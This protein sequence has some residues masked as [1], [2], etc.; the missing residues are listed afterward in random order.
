MVSQTWKICR[1]QTDTS[2][3]G[4]IWRPPQSWV[5]SNAPLVSRCRHRLY[6]GVW[7]SSGTHLLSH[8]KPSG[9]LQQLTLTMQAQ[10][11]Q[12]KRSIEKEAQKLARPGIERLWGVSSQITTGPG[13]QGGSTAKHLLTANIILTRVWGKGWGLRNHMWK[14]APWKRRSFPSQVGSAEGLAP[15][16]RGPTSPASRRQ[17]L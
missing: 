9:G 16:W 10:S 11:C 7:K 15:P 3:R 13:L 5:S 4:P 1:L 17:R 12:I 8:P 2:S 6:S 14:G